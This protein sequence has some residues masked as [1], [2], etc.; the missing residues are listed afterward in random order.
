MKKI[1]LSISI[2]ITLLFCI[3]SLEMFSEKNEFSAKTN[4]IANT[5]SPYNKDAPTLKLRIMHTNDIHGH[6]F[7]ENDNGCIGIAKLISIKNKFFKDA[8]MTLF[9][10]SGDIFCGT[11]FSDM[12]QGKSM[13]SIIN[14]SEYDAFTPGNHDW[15]YGKN[16]LKR[17]ENN[18]VF[19]MLDGNIMLDRGRMQDE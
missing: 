14:D 4:L 15:N 13:L 3:G 11:D 9:L 16:K 12:D 6:V 1:L 10:D 7:R 5:Q 18:A 2:V 17:L 8:D 19:Y